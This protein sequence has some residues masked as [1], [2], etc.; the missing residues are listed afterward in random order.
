MNTNP[1]DPDETVVFPAV[2]AREDDETRI[3][4]KVTDPRDELTVIRS[5]PTNEELASVA[6]ATVRM[7]RADATMVMLDP[8]LSLG[9]RGFYR[10]LIR[11]AGDHA[12]RSNQARLDVLTGILDFEPDLEDEVTV[13]AAPGQ[14]QSSRMAYVAHTLTGPILLYMRSGGDPAGAVSGHLTESLLSWR[15]FVAHPALRLA[16]V[17]ELSGSPMS[18]LLRLTYRDIME[19]IVARRY[20][21]ISG[22][23]ISAVNQIAKLDA[24]CSQMI[25]DLTVT[26]LLPPGVVPNSEDFAPGMKQLRW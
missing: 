7:E 12:D 22:S 15:S 11:V 10:A 4:P 21:R 25:V 6:D 17:H 16:A 24:S 9:S 20:N 23:L 5:N 19:A 2:V 3:I 8:G 14:I 1:I 18:S 13:P 26:C